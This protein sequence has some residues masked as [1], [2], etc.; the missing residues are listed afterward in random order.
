M[1]KTAIRML[2]LLIN[3]ARLSDPLKFAPSAAMLIETCAQST[4]AEFFQ[5]TN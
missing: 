1:H 4:F 5:P 2:N 3:L